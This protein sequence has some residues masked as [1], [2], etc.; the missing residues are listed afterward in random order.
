MDNHLFQS[1]PMDLSSLESLQSLNC[2]KSAVAGWP[3]LPASLEILD[4]TD[5][6]VH[7][8]RP[9]SADTT[10]VRNLRVARLAGCTCDS[11]ILGSI[12]KSECSA[13]TYL[14]LDFETSKTSPDNWPVFLD[15]LRGGCLRELTYLRI[16]YS[17][18]SD[19][20]IDDLVANCCKLET[21]DVSSPRM[22]GVFV[23]GLITAPGSRVKR[24]VLRN[25]NRVSTDTD[26][27]A[28]QRGVVVERTDSEGSRRSG[29]RVHG[30][31]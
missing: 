28:R 23:V 8:P 14:D 24:L 27:W 22:T 26:G 17:M 13:L 16:W 11:R 30:L 6:V 9:T 25:C 20:H 21:V 29:R 19:S 15:V 31:D 3:I 4:W 5:F 7:E 12:I 10:P 1:S 18:L 2:S